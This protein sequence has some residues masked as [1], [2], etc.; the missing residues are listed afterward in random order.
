MILAFAVT[1]HKSQGLSIDNTII[2]LSDRVFNPG[3]AYAALS[4]VSTLS[5]VHLTAFEPSSIIADGSCIKEINRLRQV[6]RPDLPQYTIPDECGSRK[7]KLT[8]KN[9][10]DELTVKSKREWNCQK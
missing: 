2:E 4:C 10:I 1:M 7:R 6:Y 3:M 8:G 5:G 9:V